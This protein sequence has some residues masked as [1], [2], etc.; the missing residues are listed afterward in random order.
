MN[1]NLDLTTPVQFVK[2][3]G[4]ARAK[5]FQ[6][7]GIETRTITNSEGEFKSGEGLFDDD[8]K[9]EEDK[10]IQDIV[11]KICSLDILSV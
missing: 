6:K 3:V 1:N 4:P 11:E 5:T 10:I 8:P 9:G 7:L 2:G